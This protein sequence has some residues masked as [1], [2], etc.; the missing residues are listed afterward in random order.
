[1]GVGGMTDISDE[2]PREGRF[3]RLQRYLRLTALIA[4]PAIC[5]TCAMAVGYFAHGVINAK[6]APDVSKLA[7]SILKSDNASPEMQDWAFEALGIHTEA[8]LAV[9]SIKPAR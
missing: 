9:G 7:V 1:M 5:V 3:H 8:P 6:P 2:L 4:S